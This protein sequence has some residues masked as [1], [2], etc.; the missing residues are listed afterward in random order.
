VWDSPTAV[1]IATHHASRR[2]LPVLE[3]AYTLDDTAQ[4]RALE[5]GDPVQLT[6]SDIGFVGRVAHVWSVR[7]APVREVVLRLW[8]IPGRDF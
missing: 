2:A 6:D 1:K 3:V 7:V 5:P 8:S 4:M